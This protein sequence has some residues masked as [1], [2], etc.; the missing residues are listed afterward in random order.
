MLHPVR[1]R[2]LEH[3]AEPLSAAGVARQLGIPRQHVNYHLRE[4]ESAGLVE[5]V[6]ERRKGNCLERVVRA[7]AKSYVIAPQALGSLGA[8]SEIVRDRFSIAYLISLGA[9]LIRDLTTIAARAAAAGKRVAT[10]GIETEIR[11]ASAADRSAFAED[12]TKT[13]ALLTAKYH[14]ADAPTG[15]SF[16][17]VLG[18]FPTITKKEA[19]ASD[20]VRLE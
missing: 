13:I 8:T 19:P 6:E 16:S 11:F 18:V 20:P 5:F 9:R 1:M 4:L 15:R 12:L 14:N 3:L 2:V 10:L 7:T 17:L